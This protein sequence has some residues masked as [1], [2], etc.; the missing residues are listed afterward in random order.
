[1]RGLSIIMMIMVWVNGQQTCLCYIILLGN[2]TGLI[3]KSGKVNINSGSER[4]LNTRIFI[5]SS[6]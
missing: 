3:F 6:P 1:M 2:R 4:H 5:L